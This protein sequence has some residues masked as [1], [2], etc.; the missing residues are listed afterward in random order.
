MTNYRLFK[1]ID[2]IKLV[3]NNNCELENFMLYN[4]YITVTKDVDNVFYFQ[5]VNHNRK[6]VTL[7][8]KDIIVTFIN[9]GQD[10]K[11]IE[12]KLISEDF[13]NGKYKLVL[14]K[15]EVFNLPIGDYRVIFTI[16]DTD[17]GTDIL[18]YSGEDFNPI[19]EAKV[20]DKVFETFRPSIKLNPKEFKW[21]SNIN[22]YIS[23]ILDSSKVLQ[24]LSCLYST[25]WEFKDFIG[26][27][28]IQACY[29]EN[30]S[31]R[32]EDWETIVE[33]FIG[34]VPDDDKH[35]FP[36]ELT[37][38]SRVPQGD[39]SDPY[40]Q[41][42]TPIYQPELPEDIPGYVRFTGTKVFSFNSQGRYF[43]LCYTPYKLFDFEINGSIEKVLFRS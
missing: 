11:L 41:L 1:Y 29:L 32:N 35:K 21:E 14:S 30:A 27:I 4:R 40:H 5:T 6:A 42:S 19:L 7:P 31:E 18:L 8:G 22:R 34:E 43:R 3:I 33:E 23:S 38:W 10:I 15:E 17:E 24:R 13:E 26:T 9:Y 28:M 39:P 2:R 16:K 12:K 25:S 37:P 36:V 20:T